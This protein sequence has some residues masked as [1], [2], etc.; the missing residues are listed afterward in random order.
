[1]TDYSMVAFTGTRQGMTEDQKEQFAT[2]FPPEAQVF[3]HGDCVG[4]DAE[5]HSLVRDIK[6]PIEIAIMP[7]ENPKLRAF[8][9]GDLVV[10]PRPYLERNRYLVNWADLVI[11][12][13]KTWDSRPRS[14]TWYT[15]RYA[16]GQ[17]K[18]LWII[19]PNGS[20]T[21]HG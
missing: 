4:A 16:I 11:A 12:T 5:A 20:I 2:I 19:N 13:P 6:R 18:R 3:M 7:P 17:N 14:G 8:M 1:M 15:I 9:E 10:K 21:I